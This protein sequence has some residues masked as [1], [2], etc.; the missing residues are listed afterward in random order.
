MS[1]YDFFFPE[2]AQ[3]T[4]L[5]EIARSQRTGKRDSRSRKRE[6]KKRIDDLED[7][8]GYV[9]LVLGSLLQKLDEKGHVTRDEARAVM[10]ELDGLDGAQDGKLDINILKGIS[11]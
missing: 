10:S 9:A 5:R 8:L 1:L 2:Q 7:D 4:H 11:L 6:S 3:A